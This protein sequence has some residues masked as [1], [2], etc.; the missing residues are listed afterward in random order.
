MEDTP[1]YFDS[2][3]TEL[4]YYKQKKDY[5]DNEKIKYENII[6]GLLNKIDQMKNEQ[7]DFNYLN[8]EN[9]SLK[10]KVNQLQIDLENIKQ[11]WRDDVDK[12]VEENISLEKMNQNLQQSVFTLTERLNKEHS[13][14]DS[15]NV[16]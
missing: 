16:C 13:L 9:K 2:K 14:N 12:K 3:E 6:K 5:F 11:S 4:K 1:P 15:L 7:H 8:E 10:N